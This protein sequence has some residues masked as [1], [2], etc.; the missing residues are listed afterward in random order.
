MAA[1]RRIRQEPLDI[2]RVVE[3]LDKGIGQATRAGEV[4]MRMRSMAQRHEFEAKPM[5]IEQALS[6]CVALVKLDCELHDVRIQPHPAGPLPAVMAD[7]LY[8]QQVVLNLLRNAMQ[9]MELAQSGA[10]REIDVACASSRW[11]WVAIA[12]TGPGIAKDDLERVFESFYS[13]KPG[14]LGVGLAIC[15]KLIEAQGGALWAQH[16]LGGGALFQFSLPVA[17]SVGSR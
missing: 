6:D 9:A 8:L 7:E 17:A 15:R 5:D 3:L 13:T 11:K 16:N 10:S 1:R 12:D 4:V 14:G 2:P